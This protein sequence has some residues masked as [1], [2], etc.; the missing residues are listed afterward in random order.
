MDDAAKQQNIFR[1][2]KQLDDLEVAINGNRDLLQSN[3]EEVER[4]LASL[5]TLPRRLADAER[6]VVDTDRDLLAAL[7][8]LDGALAAWEDMG[9]DAVFWPELD[10][11]AEFLESNQF[12]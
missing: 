9:G 4:L 1:V 7:T 12:T 11:W 6:N 3:Q 8:D 2:K 10:Y 5:H